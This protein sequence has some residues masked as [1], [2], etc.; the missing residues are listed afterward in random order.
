MTRAE[1]AIVR[2][3][4]LAMRRR[5]L[6]NVQAARELGM[7]ESGIRALLGGASRAGLESLAR[8]VAWEPDRFK[9]MILPYLELLGSSRLPDRSS[10]VDAEQPIEAAG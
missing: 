8:L 9:P 5:G 3:L 6:N 1:W 10:P 2:Q 4:E 7:A